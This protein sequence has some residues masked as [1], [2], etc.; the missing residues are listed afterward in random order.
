MIRILAPVRTAGK[1]SL[2]RLTAVTAASSI[3]RI[4]AALWREL[5]AASHSVTYSARRASDGSTAAARREGK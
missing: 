2:I 5:F 3:S 4:S 1:S